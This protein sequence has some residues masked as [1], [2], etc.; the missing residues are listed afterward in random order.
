MFVYHQKRI[1][2]FASRPVKI[3]AREAKISSGEKNYGLL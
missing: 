3:I 2:Y 1:A